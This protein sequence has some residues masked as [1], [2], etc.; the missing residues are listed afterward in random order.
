MI[1]YRF[2][3]KNLKSFYTKCWYFSYWGLREDRG[4]MLSG[5]C[6]AILGHYG[7]IIKFNTHVLIVAVPLFMPCMKLKE[8]KQACT[9]KFTILL[10]HFL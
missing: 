1:K 2:I 10:T 9:L 8:V 4:C 5:F 7:K 6:F 3:W